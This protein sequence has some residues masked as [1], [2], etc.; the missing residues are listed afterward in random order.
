MG[1]DK[2]A[3]QDLDAGATAVLGRPLT[4]SEHEKTRKYLELL[5]KWNRIH[6]LVGSSDPVWML[7]NV[8][9]DSLLFLRVLPA[10]AVDVADLGSGAGVP[11]V[12]IA[13]VRRDLRLTLIESRQKRVSF[14]ATVVREL[15]LGNVRI[16][17]DRAE[18][19]PE[20][21]AFDAVVARCAGRP[22]RV[23]DVG[24]ALLR[25]GGT[26]VI[27]GPPATR[28]SPGAPWVSVPGIRRGSTR[29]FAVYER[30]NSGL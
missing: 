22:E 4:A 25:P 20:A 27:S 8:V 24:L 2:S 15:A 7:E 29:S 5:R 26:L 13:V 9:F 19:L 1:A 14:L 28:G 21:N 17:A 12:P 3:E 6:R 11:G 10:S 30:V 18:R 23:V 16:V